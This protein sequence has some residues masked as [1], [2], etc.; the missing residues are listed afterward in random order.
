MTF[1]FTFALLP[2]GLYRELIKLLLGKRLFRVFNVIYIYFVIVF[3]VILLTL[4]LLF[5]QEEDDYDD[6]KNE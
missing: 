3:A 2:S 1:F 4:V 6:Q 5:D